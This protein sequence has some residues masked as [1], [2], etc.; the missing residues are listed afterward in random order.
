[1]IDT[2]VS[3]A[4]GTRLAA[5]LAQFDEFLYFPSIGWHHSW[6]RQQT[7]ISHFCRAHSTKPAVAVAPTGLIDHAPWRIQT[8]K[9]ALSRR[10][11]GARPDANAA[12]TYN[13]FP[14]NLTYIEPRFSRGTNMAFAAL[15]V[16]STRALREAKRKCGR[17]LVMACYVNPLVEKFLS[18]A[19]F[20]ILDLAERRQANTELSS[21]V[22][23]L[24]RRWSA[25][26][27]LLVADNA[28]TL[29]DYAHDRA[30]AGRPAGHLIPQGFVRPAALATEGKQARVAAY[31]GNLHAA[32]DYD[33]FAALI[34][35]NPDW[36]FKVCGQVMSE[37]AAALLAHPRVRYHGVISHDQIAD[38]LRDA[39]LGLIPYIRTEWTAGVF[40][41]KLFE[42]LSH[43]LT[44]LSTSIPEVA[45][46]ADPRF[47]QLSDEPVMLKPRR[48]S[49][50][51]LERFIEPHT[52]AARMDAYAQAISDTYA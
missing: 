49:K 40:P 43:G 27:N 47:V 1:M 31:L 48:F 10:S 8:W 37:K 51:E 15:S 28:A 17:R 12:H 38:F 29:D 50:D 13:D 11:L 25:N 30:R 16:G 46:L 33:Y 23:A 52:W 7:V 4:A 2:S 45:R 18:T 19:D 42:Y 32:I 39:S 21:A 36:T 41:T 35:R 22:R 5:A 14:Q 3:M 24:E 9:R 44:V 6:E 26:A 34:D 20:S